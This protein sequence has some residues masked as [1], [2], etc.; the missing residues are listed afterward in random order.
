MLEFLATT[1]QKRGFIWCDCYVVANVNFDPRPIL[2][3]FVIALC[4][5]SQPLNRKITK[6]ILH[7]T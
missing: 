7:V 1:C 2:Q 3:L 6:M 5:V 4:A